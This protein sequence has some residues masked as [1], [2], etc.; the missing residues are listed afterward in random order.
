MAGERILVVDDDLNICE[1][2]DLYLRNEGFILDFAH[3]GSSALSRV[4]ETDPALILL[5]VMLPVINGW[6]V[7]RMIRLNSAVP[8]I[9]LT[10]RDLVEDKVQGFELGADDY[11]VKPFE[12][13][14]LVARVK[15]R[16]KFVGSPPASAGGVVSLGNLTVDIQSYQV[17]V[18][19]KAVDL[20]PKE[21]QLLH[22]LLLNRNLVLSREKLLEKVWGYD[23]E[24]D[25]RTVDVHINRLREKVES[26]CDACKIKT[27]WG[28]GYKLEVV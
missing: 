22:F 25:T 11:L 16:L 21:I 20:K 28:V 4:K 1:L 27:V 5:D 17:T 13:R 14:E 24:G 2:I 19:G 6:E 10:A 3:D 18:N 8:I 9:F 23:C 12:P 26:R 7:C 15:T